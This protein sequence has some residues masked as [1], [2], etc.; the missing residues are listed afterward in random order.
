L[1]ELAGDIDVEEQEMA[2]SKDDGDDGEDIENTEDWV[3]ERETMTMEQLAALDKS[4]QPVRLM[5]VKVCEMMT[6]HHRLVVFTKSQLR[7]TAFAIKN[8]STI[9]LPR[10][11]EVLEELELDARMMPRDVATRWNSTFDM[12]RFAIE[13]RVAIDMVT[14]ERNMKL[15]NFELGKEEWKIA[16]E[17]CEV[18]KVCFL[19]NSLSELV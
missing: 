19:I 3:D 12:L 4:V 18:L 2:E 15:R 8:S 6:R 10:W 13:Y 7:K 9:I 5:L 17:L 16:E 1:I 14:A 11:Y